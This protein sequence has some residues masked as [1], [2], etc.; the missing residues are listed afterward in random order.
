MFNLRK[1]IFKLS[2]DEYVIA[3]KVNVTPKSVR[4]S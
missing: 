2:M 1:K 4:F 3:S